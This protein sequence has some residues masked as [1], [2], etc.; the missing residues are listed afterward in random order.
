[1]TCSKLHIEEPQPSG[2]VVQNLVTQDIFLPSV[3][4]QCSIKLQARMDGV[5]SFFQ[6]ILVNQHSSDL[7]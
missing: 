3:M 2:A 4:L 5:F 6:I 1:M 7:T